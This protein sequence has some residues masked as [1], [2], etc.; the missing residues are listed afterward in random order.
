MRLA[1]MIRFAIVDSAARSPRAISSVVRP[2]SKR[3]VRTT[4]ASMDSTGWQEMNISRSH[5]GLLI[6]RC[7]SGR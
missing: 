2:P 1:R 6:V 4:R 5:G 7:C 3:S